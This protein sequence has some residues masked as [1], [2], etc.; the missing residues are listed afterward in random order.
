MDDICVPC[1]LSHIFCGLGW[2][3]RD[4]SNVIDIDGH[5]GRGGD[6]SFHEDTGCMGM[7]DFFQ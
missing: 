1:R 3:L 2:C 6:L 7:F 4:T 5:F